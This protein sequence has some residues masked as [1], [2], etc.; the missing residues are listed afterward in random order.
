MLLQGKIIYKKIH[1]SGKGIFV[2]LS[3][4]NRYTFSPNNEKQWN[5][6]NSFKINDFVWISFFGFKKDGETTYHRWTVPETTHFYKRRCNNCENI[7]PCKR[8][9]IHFKIKHGNVYSSEMNRMDLCLFCKDSLE[10]E[11]NFSFMPFSYNV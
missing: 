10:T 4:E 11:T 3:N 9:S 2:I 1:N 7:L 8:Y 5:H 6:F